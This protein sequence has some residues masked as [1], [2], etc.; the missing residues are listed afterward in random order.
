MQSIVKKFVGMPHVQSVYTY[1]LPHTTIPLL[2][3]DQVPVLSDT[4]HGVQGIVVLTWDDISHGVDAFALT[5]VHMHARSTFVS[6]EDIFAELT[7]Q[8]AQV[9][10]HMELLLRSTIIDMREIM[11]LQLPITPAFARQIGVCLDRVLCGRWYLQ[12]MAIEPLDLLALTDL[13]DDRW[14]TKMTELIALLRRPVGKQQLPV[15]YNNLLALV[16]KIDTL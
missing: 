1:A 14:G 2:V 15:I 6:W 11:V 16:Q 13:V 10:N 9:I 7:Y 3:V 4:R 8:P 5:Y 12:T